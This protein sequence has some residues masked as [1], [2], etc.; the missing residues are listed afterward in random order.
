M[1]KFALLMLAGIAGMQFILSAQSAYPSAKQNSLKVS[2]NNST[3]KQPVKRIT[4][5][6]HKVSKVAPAEKASAKKPE[7][8]PASK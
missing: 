3:N 6:K 2:A 7:K 1:K 5:K 8:I 4:D